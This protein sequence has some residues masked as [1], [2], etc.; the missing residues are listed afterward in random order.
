MYFVYTVHLAENTIQ[1]S[2][3]K[4]GNFFLS[5]MRSSVIVIKDHIVYKIHD[6]ICDKIRN[7]V[8]DPSSSRLYSLAIV[9]VVRDQFGKLDLSFLVLY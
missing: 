8:V 6:S 9:N 5:E 7:E 3:V 1:T 2:G 4:R